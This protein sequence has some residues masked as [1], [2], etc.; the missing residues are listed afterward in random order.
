VV[1]QSQLRS[2]YV[3]YFLLGNNGTNGTNLILGD[4]KTHLTASFGRNSR[5]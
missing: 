5:T 1:L 3:Y 2:D 4:D